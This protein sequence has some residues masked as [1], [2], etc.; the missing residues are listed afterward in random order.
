MIP[1]TEFHLEKSADKQANALRYRSGD[2]NYYLAVEK[3]G[4]VKLRK[5]DGF[6]SE[7]KYFFRIKSIG[8]EIETFHTFKSLKTEEYL[9]CGN[10][11]NLFMNVVKTFDNGKPT[12]RK[13]WFRWFNYLS[14]STTQST[15]K[16]GVQYREEYIRKSDESCTE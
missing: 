14:S 1:P 4:Q 16:H 2:D 8:P 9:H 12:D 13:T 5:L 6:P 3:S 15:H 7:D 10:D 11:G